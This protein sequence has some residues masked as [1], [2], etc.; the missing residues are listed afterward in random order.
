MPTTPGAARPGP[1][2]CACMSVV[3]EPDVLARGPWAPEDVV[4]RWS[5]QHFDPRAEAAA[6]ADLAIEALRRPR[7]AQPRRPRR[8]GSSTSRAGDGRLDARPAAAALGA[9]PRRRA[10][11]PGRSPRSVS[12]ARRRTLARG[13]AR[14][15][16][17]HRGPVAGRSAPAAPS[18]SAR[19]PPARSSASSTEEWSVAPERLSGRGADPAAA[20]HGHVRRPGVA[21]ARRRGRGRRRA[22]RASPGGRP[23]STRGR[24]RPARAATH[25]PRWPARA[26]QILS[27]TGS[28]GLSFV[29][30]AIYVTRWSSGSCPVLHGAEFVFGMAHGLGWI[31]MSLLCHRRRPAA[32]RSRCGW[33]SRWPCSAASGPS[34]APR[35]SS[36]RGARRSDPGAAALESSLNGRKHDDPGRHAPDGRVGHRGNRPRW[37]KQE[38]EAIEADETLVEISTD[39]VD[40]EVPSPE[41]ARVVS[42]TSP[43]ATPSTVGQVLAEIAP[44]RRERATRADGLRAATAAAAE[45][46]PPRP[47]DG[48]GEIV[49]IV[50]PADGR[51]G[52]R[53]HDPRVGVK[54]RRRES[55]PTRRSSRSPPTRSTP[56][57]RPR[58]PARSPRSSPRRATR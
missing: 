26:A 29:H 20:R 6:E 10:T 21:G 54:A 27:T 1:V 37:H 34:S 38:G 58:P 3:P 57:C 56:S 8:H 41:Q 35:S 16:G 40:A 50:M 44:E 46:E 13:P 11:P 47:R 45:Q 7:L 39:K 31:V 43:R 25:G 33:R 28:S 48:A 23:T 30:S 32:D 15:R 19:A 55:P 49:D 42:C 17:S 9:A 18:T 5:D 52:H 4:A 12:R 22:R 2:F 36:A 14:G 24:P 51:V 53:G